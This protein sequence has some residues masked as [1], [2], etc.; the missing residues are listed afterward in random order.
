V[1]KKLIPQVVPA[2][3]GR[4]EGD[5]AG[6]GW[7]LARERFQQIFTAPYEYCELWDTIQKMHGC[8]KQN[9]ATTWA[10]GMNVI[11]SILNSLPEGCSRDELRRAF[12][13]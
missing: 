5:V 6:M 4:V 1:T 8:F 2:D 11:I 10:M 13:I 7:I 12:C 3:F 9:D